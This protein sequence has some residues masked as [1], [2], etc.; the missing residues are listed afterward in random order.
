MVVGFLVCNGG[1][2]SSIRSRLTDLSDRLGLDATVLTRLPGP[3][4]PL[5]HDNLG[6]A[7]EHAHLTVKP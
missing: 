1:M 4:V 7:R 6:D 2:L 3:A 5:D